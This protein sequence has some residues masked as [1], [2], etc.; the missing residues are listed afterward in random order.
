MDKKI[1]LITCFALALTLLLASCGGGAPSGSGAATTAAATAAAEAT[2]AAAAATTAAT[3]AA[4]TTAADNSGDADSSTV[5][6]KITFPGE[7]PIDWDMMAAE[8][9]REVRKDGINIEL[10]GTF[11]PFS[12]L[13]QKN[14]LMMNAQEPI[15]MIFDAQWVTCIE[16]CAN[17]IYA[18]IED[19]LNEYGQDIIDT[20]GGLM[21]AGYF[22]GKLYG[23]PMGSVVKQPRSW[24]V[25]YDLLKEAGIDELPKSYDE[26]VEGS[27]ILK[28]HFPNM[29]II[30]AK[31]LIAD[32]SVEL[33]VIDATGGSSGTFYLEPG[34]STIKHIAM[35]GK[36]GVFWPE[37]ER[38]RQLFVDGII[39]ND[40]LS[41][42]DNRTF[43]YEGK[44]IIATAP[45]IGFQ[46]FGALMGL[47]NSIEGSDPQNITFHT[48]D[49]GVD[50]SAFALN[51]FQF[52]PVWSS[53]KELSIQFLNWSAQ[54]QANY[55]LIAYGQE[56][57]HWEPVGDHQYTIT[58]DRWRWF[59]YA[60]VWN[61][62]H[63]RILDII[64]G[65]ALELEK[66]WRRVDHFLPSPLVGFNYDR[67]ISREVRD[68]WAVYNTILDKYTPALI[69]AIDPAEAF[70]RWLAE[71]GDNIKIILDD[72]QR[73]LDEHLASQ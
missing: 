20:R 59:P 3:T 24:Y 57:V 21:R 39:N 55:D 17:G 52:L 70:E 31:N 6:L 63:D 66:A 46:D 47:I 60:W 16:M 51:N 27:Y 18:E 11:T 64:T 4:A 61:P 8:I 50:H 62:V 29:P 15:D 68:A 58:S 33:D 30:Q 35:E 14:Q 22:S 54:S 72:M 41:V 43:F 56:G 9:S 71:D 28:E 26:L 45:D 19:L 42:N 48:L 49:D 53:N 44:C 38:A 23:V 5:T 37:L 25:R 69:G 65:D 2:T 40:A 36:D 12:D 67:N 73:Q 13:V 10:D 34:I 1:R 32:R 7:Q